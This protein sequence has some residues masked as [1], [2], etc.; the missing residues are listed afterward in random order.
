MVL[1]PTHNDT[2]WQGA[3]RRRLRKGRRVSSLR[4]QTAAGQAIQGAALV[5]SQSIFTKCRC[6]IGTTVSDCCNVPAQRREATTPVYHLPFDRKTT[7]SS[8]ANQ[9][10]FS[11]KFRSELS[12]NPGHSPPISSDRLGSNQVPPWVSNAI[13]LRLG[14]DEEFGIQRQARIL[15]MGVDQRRG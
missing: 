7:S 5:L 2:C 6:Q 15:I 14:H 11:S 12:D 8:R 3:E 10:K 1:I 9:P 4:Q 13:A